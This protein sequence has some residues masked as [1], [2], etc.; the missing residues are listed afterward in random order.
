MNLTLNILFNLGGILFLFQS[1][2]MLYK[3]KRAAQMVSGSRGLRTPSVNESSVLVYLPV[4]SSYRLQHMS[5]L[6]L[7]NFLSHAT[8]RLI[9]TTVVETPKDINHLHNQVS[10]GCYVH[11][12][13][14]VLRLVLLFHSHFVFNVNSKRCIL[15]FLKKM[16]ALIHV[17]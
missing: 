5:Q 17:E 8:Q 6:F 2:G 16:Y 11:H 9:S 1:D 14:H 4:R 7:Q 15:H 13:L 3:Y 12:N 10:T